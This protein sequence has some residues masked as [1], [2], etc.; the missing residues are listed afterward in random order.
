MPT[1]KLTDAAWQTREIE[2][3]K[4]VLKNN[5]PRTGMD[6]Q[7]LQRQLEFYGFKYTPAE[8]TALGNALV[9]E[10]IITIVP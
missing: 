6:Q 1:V 4:A 2:R 8:W 7:A 3:L 5:L 9:A 10:G